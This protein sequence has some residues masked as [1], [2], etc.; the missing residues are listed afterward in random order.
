MFAIAD[1]MQRLLTSSPFCCAFSTNDLS[2]LITILD[3]FSGYLPGPTWPGRW[4]TSLLNRL[5]GTAVFCATTCSRRVIAL[6]TSFPLMKL[7]ISLQCFVDT[8][9]FDP[10]TYA[11]L[12][13]V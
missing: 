12:S 10:L 1:A 8:G 3:A 4:P 2:R 5:N 6:L 9:K 13:M 7:A 11:A